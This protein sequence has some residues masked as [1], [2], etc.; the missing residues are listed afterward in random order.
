MG[1]KGSGVEVRAGSIRLSFQLERGAPA[2]RRTLKLGDRPM[3]PTPANVKYAHRIAGEIKD[4]IRHGTFS[5]TE[6]FPD[7]GSV[8]ADTF[9]AHLDAWLSVQRIEQ[10]TKASYTTAV[11]FWKTAL[12]DGAA[13]GDRKI[14]AVKTRHLL[15]ALATRPHLTGKTINNYVSVVRDAFTLAV[16][17]KIVADNPAA[18]ITRAKH[19]NPPADPFSRDETE[20]IISEAREIYPASTANLI[21]TWMWTGLRTSEIFGLQWPRVLLQT[22]RL[23]ISEALVSGARKGNTK[24]NVAREVLLNSRALGAL[25]AQREHTQLMGRAVFLDPA[26][27][28]PWSVQGFLKYIW[29]PLLAKLGIRYRR[30]Y[31]MRHTYATAML[32]AGMAPGFC[33]RQLG[34]SVAEFLKTYA[35]WLDGAQNAREMSRLEAAIPRGFLP[36]SSLGPRAKV[37]SDC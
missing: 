14:G 7:D 31:N 6:Y 25:Q 20:Q 4:K 18:S 11:K 27:G 34:H 37:P 26:T 2:I 24:T 30:P 35:R 36:D 5:M 12:V 29:A 16:V 13:L 23:V 9:G 33:A 21:E 19:Q 15:A 3:L 28:L 1:R 32:M 8:C 17:D 10:S 22:G